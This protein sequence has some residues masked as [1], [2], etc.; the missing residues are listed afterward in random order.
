MPLVLRKVLQKSET[1]AKA[2]AGVANILIP[3]EAAESCSCA[4]AC[5]SQA[6]SK[7]CRCILCEMCLAKILQLLA[8]LLHLHILKQY[9]TCCSVMQ[10]TDA[11]ITTE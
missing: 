3:F 8:I 6:S 7:S 4:V 5:Q 10:G 2:E 11:S 9:S 1:W